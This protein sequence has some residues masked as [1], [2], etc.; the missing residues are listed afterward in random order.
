MKVNLL[1]K[2]RNRYVIIK[3]RKKS[4]VWYSIY[5]SETQHDISIDYDSL[6]DAMS[7]YRKHLLSVLEKYTIYN[8]KPVYPKE[9]ANDDK[10]L[11]KFY[12]NL[13]SF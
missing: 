5:D 7:A 1:K 4:I 8:R 9:K 12:R 3:S 6:D 11:K 2:L 10:F 13:M